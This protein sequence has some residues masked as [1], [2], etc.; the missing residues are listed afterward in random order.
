MTPLQGKEETEGGKHTNSDTSKLDEILMLFAGGVT[1][2]QISV[3]YFEQAKSAI[4]ALLDEAR[5]DEL[6][7]LSETMLTTK[8]M[9]YVI[10]R[11]EELKSHER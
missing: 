10:A 11:N 2:D 4:Q 1:T 9:M 5:I 7:G 6:K 8:G 3:R